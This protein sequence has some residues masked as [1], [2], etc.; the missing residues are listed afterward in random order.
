[1]SAEYDSQTSANELVKFNSQFEA[2]AKED[3]TFFDVITA[4]NL[5]YN[6]NKE[7]KWDSK[8]GVEVKL[9]LDDSPKASYSILIVGALKKN[10]FFEGEG[11][12]INKQKYMYDNEFIQFT[13]TEVDKTELETSFRGIVN[14]SDITGKVDQIEL[15]KN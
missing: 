9:Y 10:H 15:R 14:Y 7:N 13:K 5:A 2:Y 4:S 8:N 12:D 11:S 1:M 6:V 3:N